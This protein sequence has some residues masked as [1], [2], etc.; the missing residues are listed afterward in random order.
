VASPSWTDY[1]GTILISH[2]ALWFL[3]DRGGR[4]E[5][6]AAKIKAQTFPY[7]NVRVEPLLA[8]LAAAAFIIDYESGG[9]HYLAIKNFK[10]H[11]TPHIKEPASTIPAPCSAPDEHQTSTGPSHPLT[12]N[13]NPIP[14]AESE[15][16]VLPPVL[17]DALTLC[18]QAYDGLMGSFATTPPIV[19]AIRDWLETIVPPERGVEMFGAACSEAALNDGKSLKYV[20]AILKRWE[21]EG[22]EDKRPSANL[23]AHNAEVREMQ[24]RTAR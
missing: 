13:H 9:H 14:V 15:S 3:A 11:Q 1:L 8:A 12:L 7:E 24:R 2:T 20:L 23:D 17:T 16:P 21:R 4:L 10:K 18:I 19:Q 5:Y 6:N 22:R